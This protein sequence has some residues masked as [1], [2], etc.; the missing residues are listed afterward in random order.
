VQVL[1]LM[2]RCKTLQRRLDK[3]L[4]KYRDRLFGMLKKQS[5]LN[6]VGVKHTLYV[7]VKFAKI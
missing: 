6:I 1:N 3:F 5:D 4:M 7:K 2:T